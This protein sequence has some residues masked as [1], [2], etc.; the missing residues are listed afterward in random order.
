[1]KKT[2]LILFF[3]TTIALGQISPNTHSFSTHIFRGT[4]LPH[5]PEL[6]H[7]QG[8]PT[9]AMLCYNIQ[10]H[11]N[12]EWHSTYNFPDYGLFFVYQN[13]NN[14]FLGE[15]FSVGGHYNF[16]FLNR[17]LQLKIAQGL[18]FANKPYNKETN[19]KNKAFGSQI[20]GNLNLGLYYKTSLLKNYLDLDIGAQFLHYSN[21]RTKSPNS[22]INSYAI[23]AGL[24][25][26]FDKPIANKID[27]LVSLKKTYNESIKGNIV[28]RTGYN[29]SAVINSGQHIFYHIGAYLDKR[30]SRKSGLQLGTDLF[31]TKS[32]KDFIQY[33]ANA[34]PELHIDPNT[35]YK[36]IGVF[37]GYEMYINKLSIEGQVGYYVYDPFK[38][39]I[40][41]YDRIGLKYYISNTI[42]T[43]ISLKTHV[44]LAEAVEYGIG[45]RF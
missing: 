29:E 11:G 28:V 43:G 45:I 19:S 32:F 5:S 10:T 13:F 27:S 21:G 9:G 34:F 25:Y 8:H 6:F 2:T 4:I 17:H 41:I 44:F 39:E 18:A 36:R 1:M 23:T 3:F 22:G 40:S 42:F 30:I 7:L 37:A 26:N 12:K 38:N 35:D 15:N 24:T 16:Y 31:L 33:K 20:L 14:E